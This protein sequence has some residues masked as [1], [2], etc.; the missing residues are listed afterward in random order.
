MQTRTGEVRA[1]VRGTSWLTEVRCEGTYVEVR[2]GV[3][4]VR[5]LIRKRTI[6]VR[7][8]QSYLARAR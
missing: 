7:A 8:G 3:V 1:T 2:E 6:Q 5:D 4:D